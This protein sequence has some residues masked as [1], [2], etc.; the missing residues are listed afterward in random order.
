MVLVAPADGAALAEGD[1]VV[2]YSQTALQP[3]ARIRVV[4]SLLPAG[5]AK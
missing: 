3:D 2:L 5:G 4:E 1:R